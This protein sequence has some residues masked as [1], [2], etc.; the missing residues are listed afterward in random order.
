[1][2]WRKR[3]EK[4]WLTEKSREKMERLSIPGCISAQG[5]LVGREGTQLKQP[6]ICFDLLLLSMHPGIVS[7]GFLLG[8]SHLFLEVEP[9]F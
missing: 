9:Q 2:G 7:W 6:T 4:L 8:F 1:V 5:R 3:L